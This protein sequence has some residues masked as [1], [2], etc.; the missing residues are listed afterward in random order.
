[1]TAKE[2]IAEELK[3]K[4]PIVGTSIWKRQRFARALSIAIE[5][6]E[7]SGA[8]HGVASTWLEYH[9]KPSP[10]LSNCIMNLNRQEELVEKALEKIEE[11]A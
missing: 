6:L 9:G 11:R 3:L 5:A 2:A 4:N 1:M 10:Q 7:A 8:M